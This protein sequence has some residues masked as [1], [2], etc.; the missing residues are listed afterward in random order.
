MAVQLRALIRM[1][2]WPKYLTYE[3]L[4]L[5]WG[6]DILHKKLDPWDTVRQAFATELKGARKL[7]A[8]GVLKFDE[9]SIPQLSSC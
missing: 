6:C 8:A 7:A 3:G 1:W 9:A 5:L 2:P 4:L